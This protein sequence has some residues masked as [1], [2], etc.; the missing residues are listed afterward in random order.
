VDPNGALYALD[1]ATGQTR[2]QRQVGVM[3]RFTTPAA[4]GP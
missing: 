3:P 1:P 2:F 4:G